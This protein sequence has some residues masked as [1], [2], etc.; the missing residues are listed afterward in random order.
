VISLSTIYFGINILSL[1]QKAINR[2]YRLFFE[3][4]ADADNYLAKITGIEDKDRQTTHMHKFETWV[5][6]CFKFA[7][8]TDIHTLY[9]P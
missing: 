2:S 7:L 4:L 9:D 8:L 3:H 1:R 6:N 5:S